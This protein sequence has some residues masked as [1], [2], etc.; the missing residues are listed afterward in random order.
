[1][2]PSSNGNKYAGLPLLLAETLRSQIYNIQS[3]LGARTNLVSLIYAETAAI[4]EADSV[5]M[6]EADRIALSSCEENIDNLRTAYE[7][8]MDNPES[9][10]TTSGKRRDYEQLLDLTTKQIMYIIHKYRLV[11]ASMMQSVSVKNWDEF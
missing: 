8:I 10:D 9:I 5:K 4:I 2:R 11:D 7:P 1:M 3:T 6:G